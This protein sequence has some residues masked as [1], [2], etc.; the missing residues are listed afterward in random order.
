MLRQRREC[1]VYGTTNHVQSYSVRI[2]QC[3]GELSGDDE[4]FVSE[5]RDLSPKAFKRLVRFIERGLTKP[6]PR[7]GK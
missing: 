1:D 6:T 2:V 5:V 3:P 4:V 7:V